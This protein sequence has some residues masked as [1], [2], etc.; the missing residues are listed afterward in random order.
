MFEIRTEIEINASA[1][2]V[3]SILTNFPDHPT[4][5]PFIHNIEG[6][7]QQGEKLTVS[8]KPKDGK[9]MTFR[10]T[11]LVAM[12]N[13]ELRWVGRLLFKGIFDGEHYFQIIEIEPNRVNFVHGEKFS[14][15]LV[16]LA[17]S[18]LNGVTK[19]SF[20]EMNKAIKRK[21]EQQA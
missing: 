5:N 20:I 21:A 1:E 3:W 8:V 6:L 14:G 10:P 11:V 13:Q 7:V 17:K 16:T 18:S 9:G 12:P 4:W 2:H 15:L 19:S